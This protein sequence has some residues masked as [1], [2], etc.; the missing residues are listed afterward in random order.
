MKRFHF[1]EEPLRRIKHQECRQAELRVGQ[2]QQQVQ[3][4]QDQLSQQLLQLEQ[5]FQA[6]VSATGR[7]PAW[8]WRQSH[9]SQQR[10]IAESQQALTTSR[11]SLQSAIIEM[12]KLQAELHALE[13][14]RA[15][16]WREHQEL[17]AR[18]SQMVL[19][20]NALN[21]WMRSPSDSFEVTG[22]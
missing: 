16:R 10:Q 1:P 21:Q 3:L 9:D 2:A 20:E 5:A 7:T 18:E 6:A 12:R 13:S 8:L 11:Q 19:D 15:K 4:A 22:R 17:L 14:L